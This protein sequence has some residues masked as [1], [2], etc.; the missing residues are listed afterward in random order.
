[1]PSSAEHRA[2]YQA[3][4]D[5]LDTGNGGTPLSTL[6][7]CWAAIVAFY[8]AACRVVL[9]CGGCRRF[10]FFLGRLRA[11]QGENAS[12]DGER[13]AKRFWSAAVAAALGGVRDHPT[14]PK[15]AAIAALQNRFALRR[16]RR[17]GF[18]GMI[19]NAAKKRRRPPHSKM[20]LPCG[21]RWRIALRWVARHEKAVRSPSSCR[22]MRRPGA[23]SSKVRCRLPRRFGVRRLPPLCF[24][25][26]RLRAPQEENASGDGERRAKRFWS[27][28]VAAALG[29]VG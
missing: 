29:D 5:L 2:K 14:S 20:V 23:R 26:G 1:M 13:R 24:F 3:N 15:A 11:P 21:R 10:G 8:A 17:V 27:A 25:P 18:L 7:A 22:P 6:D 4:R 9:E 28:A 12:G 16:H 19:T